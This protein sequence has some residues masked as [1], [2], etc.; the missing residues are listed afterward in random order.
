MPRL[1]KLDEILFPVEEHPV[2]VAFARDGQERKLAVPERKAIVNGRS[3]RVLGIVSRGY[4]LVT[5]MQALELAYQCCATVFPETKPGEW[6]ASAVDAPSTAGYCHI[7]LLHNSTALDFRDVPPDQRPDVFGPFIRVTNSYNGLRALGF[8]IGF[9]RKV[10]KNGMIVPDTIIQFKFNHLRRDIGE[11]VQFHVK[12]DRL[13]KLRTTFTD[14]LAGLRACKVQRAQFEPLVGAAL[15]LQPPKS[16]KPESRE[17]AD[18]GVLRKHLADMGTR[19]ADE[20]GDNAYSVFN[21]ITE[22]ASRPPENRCVRRDRHSMQQ[23]A[24]SWLTSFN[25]ACRTPGFSVDGYVQRV[26]NERAQAAEANV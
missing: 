24:G 11:T 23:L 21:T 10:C 25:A 26:A 17:A 3:Q 9:Y 1:A 14:S 8:D 22:F 12:Q 13:A 5:N 7:D 16:A 6:L 4:R 18:W 2:F 20:L 15:L 19:Y